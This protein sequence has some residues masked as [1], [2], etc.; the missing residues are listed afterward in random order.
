[1]L[2]KLKLECGKYRCYN[3]SNEKN[4]NFGKEEL[5]M[6]I[7]RIIS[8]VTAGM[9][10]AGTLGGC[11]TAKNKGEDGVKT[12]SIWTANAHSKNA[13]NEAID[14]WNKS[15]G[16][17]MGVKLIYEVKEG[18]LSQQIDLAM[19]TGSAPDLFSGNVQKLAADKLIMPI[20]DLPGGEEFVKNAYDKIDQDYKDAQYLDKNWYVPMG[21]T[22][23]GLLYN[24]EMFK[25]AGIVDENGEPTPPKTFDEMREYAKKLT[26]PSKKEYGIVFPAKWGGWNGDVL[27]CIVSEAGHGGYDPVADKYDFSALVPVMEAYL[28]IQEDGSYYP[29]AESLDNDPAR[30]RFGEGGIGMKIGYSFDVGVLTEQFPAKIEW[31]VA[32]LPVTD[33]NNMYKQYK[34]TTGSLVINSK[35]T[36]KIT[37]EQ[38]MEIYEFLCGETMIKKLYAAGCEVPY[39]DSIVEGVKL[40]TDKTGWKEFCDMVSISVD[41]PKSRPVEISGERTLAKDFVEKVWTG[42]M[43]AQ[44]AAD[45]YTKVMNDGVEK[46]RELHPEENT[47]DCVNKEWNVKRTEWMY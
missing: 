38:T 40:E 25:A 47:D 21:C 10:I 6:K 29:G 19:Q 34:R 45:N 9:L 41:A 37:P 33:L 3:K 31:G 39:A 13:Y 5:F 16:K 35:I 27:N 24:K 44:E 26:N 36:E 12:I 17:E 30:A 15:S 22:T 18:D 4:D 11:S 7:K 14:E 32:P 1:M 8:A 20:N 23:M 42:Q 28:G 43:T 2:Q 46:Y